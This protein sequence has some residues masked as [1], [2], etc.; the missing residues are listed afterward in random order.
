MPPSPTQAHFSP[1]LGGGFAQ[2][3]LS[4]I[5]L[6]MSAVILAS[7]SSSFRISSIRRSM[8][9][10][11]DT[12]T[13]FSADKISINFVTGFNP[14]FTASRT[15]V[16]CQVMFGSGR[17]LLSFA[18]IRFIAGAVPRSR[19]P[20]EDQQQVAQSYKILILIKINIVSC[21]FQGMQVCLGYY[22]L[23]CL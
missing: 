15:A 5:S 12:V 9:S 8:G 22:R 17:W 10:R 19:V 1:Q 16:S 3:S 11:D 13:Y 20:Y 14:S 4:K 7:V 23:A 2:S 21:Y 18:N 6:L